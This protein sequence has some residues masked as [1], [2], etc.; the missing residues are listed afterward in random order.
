M[1]IV[2][3]ILTLGLLY[4]AVE[5]ACYF[6][7]K[8]SLLAPPPLALR[9]DR[10][11]LD[12]SRKHDW[13]FYSR[14][15]D[16]QLALAPDRT[17][18]SV[19]TLKDSGRVVYDVTFDVDE[20]GLRRTP[21]QSGKRSKF[22]LFL[23]CSLVLGEGLEGRETIPYFF[24]RSAPEYRSYNYGLEGSGPNDILA[25]LQRTDFRDGIRERDGIAFYFIFDGHMGR[26]MGSMSDIGYC[27]MR[28]YFTEDREGRIVRHGT[29]LSGRPLTTRFYL[30]AERTQFVRFLRLLSLRQRLGLPPAGAESDYRFLARVIREIKREYARKMGNQELY[31]VFPP[32]MRFSGRL[33][34]F[35]EEMQIGYIDYSGID[36]SKQTRKPA[37]IEFDG[38]PSAASNQLIGAKLAR[39]ILAMR[40]RGRK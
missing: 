35:L 32:G 11:L 25:R 40:K 26:L 17:S 6:I 9:W 33:I 20:Y 14:T 21:G 22:A 30:W 15:A 4:W 8:Y 16:G 2:I 27:A 37:Y 38:H 23:G 31:V 34:P 13:G 3:G 39:D 10:S 28:P 7:L 29:F 5:L 36:V 24:S 1:G 19:V 18:R 12:L